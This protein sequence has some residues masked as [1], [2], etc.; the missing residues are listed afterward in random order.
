[1]AQCLKKVVSRFDLTQYEAQQCMIEMLEGKATDIQIAAFLSSLKVKGETIDELTGFSRAMRQ[2]SV[3]VKPK[4]FNNLVDTCG[5]G[6]DALKTFNVSTA[7]AIIAASVGVTVAKHGNRSITSK[8]GGADIMEALGVNLK[9][10]TND[11]ER[12]LETTG[13]GFMFAPNFHPALGRLMHIRRELNI[14]TVFNLLGPLCSPAEA[15]I[16]LLGV[17]EPSK[18]VMMARVLQNLGVKRAMVVHGFD[19]N[20]QPAM[21]EISTLGKTRIAFINGSQMN[22]RNIYPEDFGLKR[23]FR[24]DLMAFDSLEANLSIIKNVLTGVTD[25][26]ADEARLNLC[27]ANASAILLLTGKTDDLREG[28]EL[29]RKN[30]FKGNAYQKLVELVKVSNRNSECNN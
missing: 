2:L 11:V 30:V 16:Q 6:G 4:N 26:S 27:L 15:P 3:K 7:A 12:C 23:A 13:I 1:M 9:C 28:V 14:A 19:E 20:N 21:D 5:T 22:I 17:F 29:A 8:C 18:V 24:Q 10:S 25:S